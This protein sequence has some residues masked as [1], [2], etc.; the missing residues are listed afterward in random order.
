MRVTYSATE[1]LGDY[2]QRALRRHATKD[3]TGVIPADPLQVDFDWVKARLVPTGQHR[4]RVR[5]A[6]VH[7]PVVWPSPPVRRPVFEEKL[8]PHQLRMTEAKQGGC[9]RCGS[10]ERLH[11]HHTD[12]A[13]KEH[14]FTSTL[15]DETFWA[16]VAKCK[17]LCAD[18]H[19]QVHRELAV[20]QRYLPV[21]RFCPIPSWGI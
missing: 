7:G 5:A 16:E 4:P 2:V 8:D 21:I 12:P 20:G 6:A 3:D 1:L 18:C 11:L 14:D 9:R 13:A 19:S 15:D 17:V 10:I